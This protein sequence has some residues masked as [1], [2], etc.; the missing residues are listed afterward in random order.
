MI[1]DYLLEDDGEEKTTDLPEEE[2]P[3]TDEPVE[4]DA[5]GTETEV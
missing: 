3:A 4:D 5:E 1:N 2:T